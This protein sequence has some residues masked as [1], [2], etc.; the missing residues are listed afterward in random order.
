MR[1]LRN[2]TLVVE[3]V[4][5]SRGGTN[6]AIKSISVAVKNAYWLRL[7]SIEVYRLLSL[8]L[9]LDSYQLSV[10]DFDTTL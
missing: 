7:C 5:L 1:N 6:T 9:V 10:Q 2:L 3:A 4:Q 8:G